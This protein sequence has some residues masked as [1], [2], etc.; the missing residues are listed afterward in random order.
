MPLLL[1]LPLTSA[2]TGGVAEEEEEEAGDLPLGTGPNPPPRGGCLLS[3]S[4]LSLRPPV[5]ILMKLPKMFP[6][7]V[8]GG[9][10]ASLSPPLLLVALLLLVGAEAGLPAVAAPASLPWPCS[11]LPATAFLVEAPVLVSEEL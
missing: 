7:P 10:G 11:R 5:N 4:A 2:P 1:P 8:E 6:P 9:A 3:A